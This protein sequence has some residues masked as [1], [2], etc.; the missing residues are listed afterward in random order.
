MHISWNTV[1]LAAIGGG[2]LLTAAYTLLAVRHLRTEFRYPEMNKDLLESAARATDGQT[3]GFNID[4]DAQEFFGTARKTISKKFEP[5]LW[6][7]WAA[8]LLSAGLFGL[9]WFFR[10]RWYLD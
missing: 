1:F 7:T 8:L 5:P 10:K 3:V 9:E 4:L 6:D 2:Y